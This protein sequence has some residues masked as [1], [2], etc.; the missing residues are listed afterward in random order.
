MDFNS[1]LYLDKLG[2]IGLIKDPGHTWWSETNIAVFMPAIPNMM[3][4]HFGTQTEL[5]GKTPSRND[6]IP[7]LIP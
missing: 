3:K 5:R 6:S 2:M 1:L 7:S 4:L